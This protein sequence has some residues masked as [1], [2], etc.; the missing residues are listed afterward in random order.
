MPRKPLASAR[1]PQEWMDQ[2]QAICTAT[3]KTPS[4]VVQDAIATYL[5]QAN[6]SQVNRVN[7]SEERVISIEGKLEELIRLTRLTQTEKEIPPQ[8][9][10]Q[11]STG[12][13]REEGVEV[14]SAD[15]P[16]LKG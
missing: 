11:R 7:P 9:L 13:T 8:A 1:I 2:I 12:L 4:E 6:L 10:S 5:N 3:G 14:K 16:L 15:S